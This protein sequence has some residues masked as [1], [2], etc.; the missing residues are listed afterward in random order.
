MQHWVKL[1]KRVVYKKAFTL[2]KK[3]GLLEITITLF[4]DRL[5]RDFSLAN[6]FN[7]KVQLRNII[8]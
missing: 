7:C 4:Q 8:T 6:I 1:Q 2:M 5:L 3:K